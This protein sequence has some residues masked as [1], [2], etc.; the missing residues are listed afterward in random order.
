MV[1]VWKVLQVLQPIS[2]IHL[3]AL[4]R[5]LIPVV[6]FGLPLIVPHVPVHLILDLLI[7]ALLV[8]LLLVLIF[9]VAA[10]GWLPRVLE[11]TG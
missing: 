4:L 10:S 1:K 2:T 9:I 3:I 11:M 7:I 5:I 6:S 8:L